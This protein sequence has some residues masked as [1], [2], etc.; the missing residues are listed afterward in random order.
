LTSEVE[1][2][3]TAIAKL[4]SEHAAKQ[5][6]LD[7]QISRVAPEL[8]EYQ[9]LLNMRIDPVQPDILQVRYTN[10]DASNHEREFTVLL[11]VSQND[12]RVPSSKP[13]LPSLPSLVETLN[14][15]RDF[16]AFLKH[17]RMAFVEYAHDE[18]GERERL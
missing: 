17:I 11:D 13:L 10:V 5:R 6:A 7:E 14:R 8:A 16:F 4:R 2:V 15:D 1:Q 18:R 12:Y 9:R 3:K